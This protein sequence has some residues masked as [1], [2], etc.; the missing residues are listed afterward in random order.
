VAPIELSLVHRALELRVPVRISR[1]VE[2]V[3]DL[4]DVE[5]RLGEHRGRGEAAPQADNGE[6]VAGTVAFLEA[7]AA[8]L[9]EDPFAFDAIEEALA[10]LPPAPSARAAL[11]AALHDLVGQLTGQP[12]WRLLGLRRAGPPTVWTVS[13]D[14][15]DAMAR[16]AREAVARFRHLKL[17]LG[18]R[19]GLDLERVRAVRAA[20]DVPLMA[21]VN[22]AWS[23]DEALELLP[24]M[25]D[26][27]LETIEQ[28]L[29]AGDDRAEELKRRSPIPVYLDEE[30]KQLSDLPACAARGHGINVKIMKVGGIRPA[31]RAVAA[32]RALGLRTMLGCMCEST[33][34]IAAGCQVASAFDHVDLDGNVLMVGDPYAGVELV[35]GVQLPSDEPGL[36]VRDAPPAAR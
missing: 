3:I 20:V 19:D 16:D 1:G 17:K 24:P 4:V 33:L 8:R 26:V 2:E 34:G 15:P 29:A 35:D 23:F 25:A 7:A 6:T 22:A 27:G 28:P 12:T 14:D 13:L 10:D 32:A 31:L 21:D 18:G 36:G 9:G 5:L 11:D 30:W